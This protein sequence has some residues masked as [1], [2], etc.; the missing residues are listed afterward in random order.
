VDPSE[1]D[2]ALDE[3]ENRLD[4][5]RSLYEQYF[6]GI[7]KIEPQVARKDVDRRFWL[8]RR[9]QI[10]NTA[11][12]FR[13]QVLVQRYNTFQQYWARICR[14][15][16]NGTYTRHLLRAEKK[17]GEEP[18]TWAAK[19]RLGYFR[20]GR[21][22]EDDDGTLDRDA[23]TLP[24]TVDDLRA[25][26]D[27]T[28]DLNEEAERAAAEALANAERPRERTPS[29]RSDLG[30]L[31]LDFDEAPTLPP[32][33]TPPRV[34]QA[35]APPP[36]GTQPD[37]PIG[38]RNGTAILAGPPT[39]AAGQV[40]AR[41]PTTA[42]QATSAAPRP[43][44]PAAQRPSPPSPATTSAAPRPSPQPPAAAAGQRPPPQSPATTG[45]ALRPSPQ[46][47]EVRAA[48]PE[49]APRPR[50]AASPSARSPGAP[51]SPLG[52]VRSAPQGTAGTRPLGPG[53]EARTAAPLRAAPNGQPGSPAFAA[54]PQ[55]PPAAGVHPR[56]VTAPATPGVKP[57]PVQATPPARPGGAKPASS[58]SP[59]GLSEDRVRQ[60]HAEL[61]E[62]KRKLNQGE[63]VSLASLEKSLRETEKRLREQ[64]QGRSVDFHVVVKDGKPVVKPVVRK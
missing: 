64:H 48:G 56:S 32:Q 21:D 10:R 52:A 8:L 14:E 9:T 1:I 5:L 38:P 51:A 7:E 23:E 60:L 27:S 47:P 22:T 11:R 20:K 55:A 49:P 19:K 30:T 42:A 18:K 44:A 59:G 43:P 25:M 40:A 15:I 29:S 35:A 33:R 37:R 3:L 6:L 2:I 34:A 28:L 4:R 39:G 61:V 13:L 17:L 46:P 63:A 54:R 53:S 57:A 41:Q 45:A 62:T 12:R 31:D 36:V 50:P 26:L 24:E 58:G 16:E